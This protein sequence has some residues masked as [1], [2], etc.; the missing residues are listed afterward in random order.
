MHDGPCFPG[1]GWTS[2]VVDV[3]VA[4]GSVN[5]PPVLLCSHEWLLLYLGNCLYLNPRALTPLPSQFSVRPTWGEDMH[6]CVVLSCCSAKA[7]PM[8]GEPLRYHSAALQQ[9]RHD[10]K[11]AGLPT[12]KEEEK[13]GNRDIFWSVKECMSQLLPLETPC[14]LVAAVGLKQESTGPDSNFF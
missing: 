14:L 2:G 3:D 6:G 12:A 9:C 10:Q 8:F 7:Q 13:K 1:S 4:H 5:E 11:V